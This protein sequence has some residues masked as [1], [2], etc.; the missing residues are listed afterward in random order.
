MKIKT[1]DTI[2]ILRGYVE[3]LILG[4]RLSDEIVPETMEKALQRVEDTL[5]LLAESDPMETKSLKDAELKPFVPKKTG[6]VKK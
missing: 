3:G 5:K 2:N 4:V 1:W 6:K